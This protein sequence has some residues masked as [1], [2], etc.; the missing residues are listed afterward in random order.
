MAKKLLLLFLDL[1][2]PMISQAQIVFPVPGR[3]SQFAGG[4][5]D[6]NCD[7]GLCPGPVPKLFAICCPMQSIATK[8]VLEVLAFCAYWARCIRSLQMLLGFELLE[9]QEMSK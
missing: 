1:E 4:G 5:G 7:L 3:I 8:I 9:V 6:Q 2:V